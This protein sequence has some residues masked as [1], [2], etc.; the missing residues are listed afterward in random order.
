MKNRVRIGILLLSSYLVAGGV[1]ITK[2]LESI[3]IQENDK[4]IKIE[5]IQ[6]TKHRLTS[7]F[8]KTSR[9]CPP[10]CVQPMNIG[11]TKTIGEIELL[12]YIKDMQED[13]GNMLLIDART[14]DWYK[15]S[16]IP[17]SINLPFT[18]LKKNSKYLN[19]IL[20]L[21]GAKK[22]DGK[23]NF[24]KVPTMI[25]FSNGIWDA[26]ATKEINSLLELGC[27]ADKIL[28]YRGGMQSW[29]ILGLTVK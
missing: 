3:V 1:N 23:W 21:L 6:D 16:T 29:N 14:R 12:K 10:F 22:I 18:M 17:S 25:I 26:Q 5:R 11:N 28:Y 19:K 8:S 4:S 13:D 15:E 24:D 9:E 7:S 2:D 20:K 27:P